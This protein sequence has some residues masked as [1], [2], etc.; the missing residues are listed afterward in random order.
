M[1][2]EG[3]HQ[4]REDRELATPSHHLGHDDVYELHICIGVQFL[5]REPLTVFMRIA[6]VMIAGSD[7]Y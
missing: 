7:A 5:H 6:K 2:D 4:S 3:W 1:E